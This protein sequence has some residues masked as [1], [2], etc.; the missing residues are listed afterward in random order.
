[1][2]NFVLSRSLKRR[3]LA[4]LG[5]V[6]VSGL[7]AFSQTPTGTLAGV[8]SDAAK[9]PVSEVIVTAKKLDDGVV[10]AAVTGKDGAYQ[11]NDVAPGAYSVLAQKQG[12]ADFTVA[13][14][15]IAA[16]SPTTTN[17]TL[18]SNAP[19]T[20]TAAHPNFMKR[21]GKAYW[22]DWHPSPTAASGPAPA[23]RGYAAPESNPPYPFSSWPMG[24][25]VNI[26]QPF[27]FSNPLMIALYDGPNGD[28]WKKSKIGLFGW[29]N[30]GMNFSTS[31][32][33]PY[34]NA[35]AAYPQIPNSIQL[36]QL[37]FYIERQPDTVQKDHF[38]WGFQLTNLYGFDYRFTTAKGIF[39][40]QLLNNPKPDGSIGNKYG[41]DPVMY[42]VDLYF[43]QVGQGMDVRVGRY[44]SL[45][46]IE[47][48]LAPNNYTYTHS[49]TYS[50]DCYTQQGVNTTTK[51]TDHWTVQLG[52]SGGCESALWK[53]DAQVT[54]NICVAY[55]WSQGG[56]DVY[57]CANSL[58]D[59]KYSYNNLAAYYATWYHKIN[60]N[61]HT[62][63]EAW[64][65]YTLDTPN[66]NN[67]AAASLIQ[68]N[69]NGARCN[70]PDE[71]TCD[72]TSWA[73]VN[74]TSRQLGAHDFITIRNEFF[75]DHR[76][77]R[78]GYKTR[79]EE[80]GIGWNHWVGSSIV[81]RPE[82][83]YEHA[84]DFTAYDNGTKKSQF[85]FAADVIFFY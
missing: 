44:I 51:I 68:T 80:N 84:F 23:F 17:L 19:A 12:Y 81:L 61:W 58:N 9:A 33:L 60:K 77:Q 31:N 79:Y 56:D 46:D 39:S 34:G 30:A 53:H 55:F 47:A 36:D 27:S 42:Y 74:Y 10:R 65:Q 26:G 21:L 40:Q 72:A 5:A 24:G 38:D 54:G 7:S 52:I 50:Y 37:T 66:A 18:T 15:Q 45:P 64:Y 83:R 57:V 25:T 59:S 13:S 62:A 2:W 78:T 69:S 4:A 71:L 14:V 16:G 76:G 3:W 43:P 32:A 6:L 85:M 35:P 67:P 63:T 73:T 41:Y 20:T 11:I 1:M 70:R 28:W 49:L 82:L 29:A 8:A 22:D 75:D 48:Q